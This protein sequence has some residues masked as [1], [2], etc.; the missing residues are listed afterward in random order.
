MS[1]K[2]TYGGMELD[3]LEL[4]AFNAGRRVGLEEAAKY[5]LTWFAD[6]N[7][8]SMANGIRALVNPTAQI[9]ART[10]Q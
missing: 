5:I 7:R 10:E 6:P 9:D 1:T 2:H 4:A 3:E 8:G